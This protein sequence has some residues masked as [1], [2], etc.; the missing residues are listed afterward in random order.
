LLIQVKLD[1]GAHHWTPDFQPRG[2]LSA[3]SH[4]TARTVVAEFAAERLSNAT[5]KLADVCS[6]NA[7][8]VINAVPVLGAILKIITLLRDG[9]PIG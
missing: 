1:D 3:S 4:R 5:E 7:R 2:G 6:L 9:C 8:D